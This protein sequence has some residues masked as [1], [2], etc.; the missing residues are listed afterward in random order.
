Y[1]LCV[2][3]DDT[4]EKGDRAFPAPAEPD[5][6]RPGDTSRLL[7]AYW[8]RFGEL[9][10]FVGFPRWRGLSGVFLPWHA[11]AC[12]AH[13]GVVLHDCLL[14][15]QDVFHTLCSLFDAAFSSTH[16]LAVRVLLARFLRAPV[17]A[18]D[19]ARKTLNLRYLCCPPRTV[20][21]T[22]KFFVRP[23]SMLSL[24]NHDR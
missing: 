10:P 15:L 19:R 23:A 22:L 11:G 16:V 5:R 8:L 7:V 12:A 6:R 18:V 20:P 9:V 2:S 13:L 21:R 4:M 17:F 24:L 3:G 14:C 1:G